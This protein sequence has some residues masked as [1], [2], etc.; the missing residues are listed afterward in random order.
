[1]G[2]PGRIPAAEEVALPS[3]LK[4]LLPPDRIRDEASVRQLF[5]QDVYRRGEL[6]LA[7]VSPQSTEE[8]SKVL[9]AATQAGW[10]KKY[11]KLNKDEYA[12]SLE[13]ECD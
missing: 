3:A 11:G 6:P 13:E 2:A 10:K 12:A 4:S 8:V 9:A 1:M 5:A 7:V